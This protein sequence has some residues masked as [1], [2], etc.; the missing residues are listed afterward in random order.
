P[1]SKG[2]TVHA[3]GMDVVD[4][5]TVFGVEADAEVGS[6]V[7]VIEG[8]VR[9]QPA[10]TSP[11]AFEPVV[12]ETNQARRVTPETGQL[13]SFVVNERPVFH[14]EPVH[15]YVAAVLESKPV[16][17]WRFEAADLTRVPNEITP[18]QNDLRAFGGVQHHNQGLL[19]RAAWFDNRDRQTAYFETQDHFGAIG[20][21]APFTIELWCWID[22]E[23]TQETGSGSLAS[24]YGRE[25]DKEV[26]HHLVHIELQPNDAPPEWH[27][28]SVRV[29][30]TDL[31]YQ[32]GDVHGLFSD[33][34]YELK[35][36]QHVVVTRQDRQLMLYLDGRPVGPLEGNVMQAEQAAFV[37]GRSV[38]LDRWLK[39]TRIDE[40]AFYDRAMTGDEIQSHWQAIQPPDQARPN[41]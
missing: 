31:R 24:L 39:N 32:D 6:S 11:L 37:I 17:F 12:L 22:E 40:V 4:L 7:L 19:G 27:P 35:K 28:G 26:Q 34:S 41:P 36:W 33:E 29:H 38:W 13:E 16:A 14:P 21:D 20:P 18:G 23:L 5:G 10:T 9:A 8:S 1:S 15:P 25:S 30:Y 2:F 3:P